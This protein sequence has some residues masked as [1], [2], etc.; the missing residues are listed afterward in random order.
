MSRREGIS[1]PIDIGTNGNLD[2]RLK[3]WLSN[4][5]AKGLSTKYASF[6]HCPGKTFQ[7]FCVLLLVIDVLYAV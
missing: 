3:I 7:A 2:R 5:S 4:S 6:I 1:P